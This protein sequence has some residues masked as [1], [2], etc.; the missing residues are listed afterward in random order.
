MHSELVRETASTHGVPQHTDF[1]LQEAA[2]S[3]SRE[4]RIHRLEIRK[5]RLDDPKSEVKIL[6]DLGGLAQKP[7][8]LPRDGS[9]EIP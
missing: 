9:N 5:A 8:H 7:E 2:N 4:L 3:F 6:G 1:M